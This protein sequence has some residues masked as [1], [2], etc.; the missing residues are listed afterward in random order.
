MGPNG[1]NA[2]AVR[3]SNAVHQSKVERDLTAGAMA[4]KVEFR[5]GNTEGGE[6]LK[7]KVQWWEVSCETAVK[8]FPP[9]APN[10]VC[11]QELT[12]PAADVLFD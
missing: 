11:N 2:F 10:V 4:N 5:Y 7:I 1:L 9:L 8:I 6:G 3:Q 12:N